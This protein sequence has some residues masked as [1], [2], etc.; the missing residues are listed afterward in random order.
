MQ[1]YAEGKTIQRHLYDDFGESNGWHD[2][3][4]IFIGDLSKNPLE[5]RIKPSPTYRPFANAEEC[6]QEMLKHQPFGV[7][8]SKGGCKSF[9]SFKCLDEASCD[10]HG[11]NGESYDS[12]L[13]DIEFTDG[14]PFG[15]KVEEE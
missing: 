3:K 10:F 9:S 11:Y 1:A 4:S 13:D 6:W 2:T 5:I 14:A 12:A 7:V 8:R 15:V